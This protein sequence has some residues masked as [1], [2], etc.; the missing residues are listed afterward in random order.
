MGFTSMNDFINEVSN[1]NKFFRLDWQK[2]VPYTL[3]AGCVYD[4][5]MFEGYPCKYWHGNMLKNGALNGS[6]NEWDTLPTGWAYNALGTVVKTAGSANSLTQTSTI[7]LTNSTPYSTAFTISGSPASS[8]TPN[9]GGTAGTARSAAGTYR[10]TITTPASTSQV[11]GISATAS[12]AGTVDDLQLQ[13]A[14]RFMAYTDYT[15]GAMYHGG[16]TTPD[17]K[18]IINIGAWT[19]T[20]TG[21]ASTLYLIDVLG[22]YPIINLATTSLQTF[23]NTITLPRYVTGDGVRAYLVINEAAG[24]TASNFTINYTNQSGVSG[25]SLGAAAVSIASSTVARVSHSGSASGCYNPFLPLQDGDTGIRSVESIQFATA[26]SAGTATLVLCRPITHIPII[27]QY[28]ASERD[29]INQIPSMPRVY[30][31]AYLN[32]LYYA[33]QAA[34]AATSLQGYLDFAWS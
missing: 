10:E 2:I 22:V 28:M 21:Y 20:A 32:I 27:N 23:D 29:L 12:G 5:A 11:F 6:S 15:E 18:H 13:E 25:R 30:D 8:L 33:G 24:S 19:N 1:N 14:L 3:A 4:L 17:T 34:V 26:N 31:G 7:T 16:N 9:I